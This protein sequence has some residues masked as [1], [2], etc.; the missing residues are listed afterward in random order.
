[1][2]TANTVRTV[3]KTFMRMDLSFSM[4]HEAAIFGTMG[5]SCRIGHDLAL[6]RDVSVLSSR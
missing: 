4:V 1:V 2:L 3:V 6:T 5:G